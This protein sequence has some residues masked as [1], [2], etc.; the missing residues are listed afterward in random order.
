VKTPI[1]NLRRRQQKTRTSAK[2]KISNALAV[3]SIGHSPVSRD[4]V[5]KVLDVEGTLESGSEEAT[6]GCNERR[7]NGHDEQ[8]KMVGR[9]W[10]RRD[11][12]PEL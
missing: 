1:K 10:E 7:E 2:R 3:H 4:T 5:T 11:I 12:S 8:M 6:E 9:I